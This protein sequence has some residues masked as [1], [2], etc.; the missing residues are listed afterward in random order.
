MAPNERNWTE[1]SAN[2]NN[3][4][5]PAMVFWWGTSTVHEIKTKDLLHFF[6]NAY[7][8]YKNTKSITISN[9]DFHAHAK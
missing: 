5:Y 1:N 2:S 3:Q 8:K 7:V 9:T 4:K 6:L